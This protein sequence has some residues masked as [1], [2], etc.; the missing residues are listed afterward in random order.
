MIHISH[1]STPLGVEIKIF[2]PLCFLF[3]SSFF[4]GSLSS[5]RHIV[6]QL[7]LAFRNIFFP[8]SQKSIHNFVA[9]K[10]YQD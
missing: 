7:S 2:S 8:H 1:D 6:A 4:I 10:M 9:D 3:L 5:G